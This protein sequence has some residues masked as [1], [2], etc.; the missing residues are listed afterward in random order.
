MEIPK[1][2]LSRDRKEQPEY[3]VIVLSSDA[4]AR[5]LLAW[6]VIALIS[7]HVPGQS[8]LEAHLHHNYAEGENYFMNSVERHEARYQRRKAEREA[9]RRKRNIEL[10]TIE[11]VFTYNNLF[12]TGKKCCNGVRWKQSAQ[13]FENHLFSRTAATRRKV[14]N[15]SWKGSGYSHFML[16][17]RGKIRPIDAPFIKDRQVH[18][19]LTNNVLYPL[20]YPYMIYDNGASQRGKGLSFSFKRLKDDLH[21]HYRRYG[22][23]GYIVL[24]DLKSFFPSAKHWAIFSR[25][26]TMIVDGKIRNLCDQIVYDFEKHSKTDYGMPLGVEPSQ[27][28]MVSLPSSIDNYAKC[29]LSIKGFAHYMDDY[30]AIFRYKSDAVRFIDDIEIQFLKMGLTINRKKCKILPMDKPFKYCKATFWVT[31]TGRVV[32]RGNRDSV[33]RTRAKARAFYRMWLDGTRTI[34]QIQQWYQV[35]IAYFRNFDD[36]NRILKL[37]RL[38]YNLFG[39]AYQCSKLSKTA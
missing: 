6:R 36:H 8:S 31:S 7:F 15:G 3:S 10:G 17:E 1:I 14:V 25:H 4:L 23:Q 16:S 38:M 20:Y 32:M 19:L 18:K 26:D 21:Y 2:A 33:K 28:E 13:N 27:I 12:R 34:E 39:G 9:R 30:Y 22:T 5:T 37:N 24:I 35:Q 11:Q 29:Q